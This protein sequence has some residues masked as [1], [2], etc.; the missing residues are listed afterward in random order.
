MQV[1]KKDID[2]HLPDFNSIIEV[3]ENLI[4]K[5]EDHLVEIQ[6]EVKSITERWEKLQ[7]SVDDHAKKTLF[8]KN[9]LDIFDDKVESIEEFLVNCEQSFND[10]EPVDIDKD[11]VNKQVSLLKV[12]KSFKFFHKLIEHGI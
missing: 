2:S 3:K 6:D 5:A 11:K 7:I 4:T 1:T 12:C 9:S 8:L 10:L